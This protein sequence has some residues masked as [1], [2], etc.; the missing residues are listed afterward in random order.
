MLKVR[1]E[2]VREWIRMDAG[3]AIRRGEREGGGMM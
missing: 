1:V 3:Y 2:A